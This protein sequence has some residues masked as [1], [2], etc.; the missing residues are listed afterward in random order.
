MRKF[1]DQELIDR[2]E[3]L[4]SFKGWYDGAYF[5]TVRSDADKFNEF[6]DRGFLYWL[7]NGEYTFIMN[8]DITTNTGAYG[9]KN[10][11]DYN[12]LGAAVLKSDMMVYNSHGYGLHKGKYPAYRQIKGFPY[13]RDGNRNNRAEEIGPEHGDP[14]GAN[15]HKAGVNSTRIGNWS[16]ACIVFKQIAKFDAF[17]KF[18]RSKGSPPLTLVILREGGV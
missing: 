16:V 11:K 17:M 8:A 6:D 3:A 7:E 15:V 13:Y 4:P 14:I 1:N 12:N 5:V 9:L 2:V 18:M 10:F